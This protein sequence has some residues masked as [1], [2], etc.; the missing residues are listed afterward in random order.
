[1]ATTDSTTETSAR[2]YRT[3]FVTVAGDR[4][5]EV[6]STLVEPVPQPLGLL[7]Q[8]GLW[9]NLG[10]SLLGFTG[11]VFVL[12]PGGAGTRQLSLVAALV[13]TVLGTLLGTVAL[14]FSALPGA[15]TGAPAMVLL[16]GLF[17]AR[18]SYLPT[19]LN[20]VQLLGWGTFELVTIAS[21]AHRIVPSAPKW[22]FVCV[23]GILTT[24]LTIRPLG[25]IRIL[26]R[27]VTG[28]VVVVLAYLLVELLRHPLPPLGRGTWS[29]FWVATDTTVA[30]AVSFVPLAA[31][32][33]RHS[34]SGR[35]AFGGALIGYSVTQIACYVIGL[36]ALVT[37]ARTPNDIYGA[38]IAVP[39]GLVAFA[40]LAA[41]ELD[42]SFAN[43][44][45]TAV[46]VQ[47]LRPRWDRRAL[48]VAVGV[49]TTGLALWANIADYEN[50][51]LLLGSVFVPLF[52]VLVVDFF[53]LGGRS[54]DLSENSRSRWAMVAPWVLGFI[55]YQLI[56]PGGISWWVSAW[57]WIAA[58]LGFTPTAWMSASICSFGVAG[59]A[60][61][62]LGAVTALGRRR[63]VL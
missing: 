14:A 42:Q 41:R 25:A 26:R 59:A 39:L 48:A 22:L 47:N 28:A 43:V 4:R 29:G 8:L 44:Y 9:G 56:N 54:W 50:F 49:I 27:Y 11:A 38:F 5:S 36:V 60:T 53:V 35:A 63:S 37:V 10:V 45:S 12:Q 19:V 20:I 7:D 51:L 17:G 33:A 16:R 23:A 32:Y 46:S 58:Q 6:P 2:P 30:V 31:D 24:L 61:L 34:R 52:A 57:K 15:R 18:L 3:V 55:T 21:A 62:A 40:V 13:A 1:M